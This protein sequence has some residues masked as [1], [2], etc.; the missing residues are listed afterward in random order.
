MAANKKRCEL[1]DYAM[2]L[3]HHKSRELVGAAGFTE[4]DVEDLEQTLALDLVERLPR[5]DAA[6]A[7]ENTFVARLVD[8]KISKLIR[9]RD[10]ARRDPE[11]EVCSLSDEVTGE[12]GLKVELGATIGQDEH[13]LRCGK[14]NRP[15]AERTDLQLDVGEAVAGLPDDLR[16]IAEALMVLPVS[17]AAR[18]LGIPR[19]KLYEV[20]LPK[21]REAFQARGL[22]KCREIPT[23]CPRTGYV[24]DRGPVRNEPPSGGQTVNVHIDLSVLISESDDQYHAQA[25]QHLSSHQLIDF[26]KSPLLHYRK[27]TGLVED[28]DSPAFLLGRAAHVRILE[29]RDA[30]QA[31]FALGGPINEKTGRPFGANTK[32][33][34]EWAETQGKPVLSQDH[35]ELIEKMAAG[36]AMNQEAVDLLLCGRV[37][38]VVRATYAT[39]SCQIRIDW[40]HP[41]RGIVDLK[42]CDELDWFE[43][44]ARRYHYANQVAFYQ[45]VLANAIG[46]AVP[47]YIVAVEKREPFRC[48]VWR[49]SD[50]ALAVARQENEAAIQRL[51]ACREVGRWPTGYEVVRVLDVA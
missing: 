50:D 3:I 26:M 25:A 39:V 28:K 31:R 16:P 46:K 45:S 6:K 33:F 34:A 41:H 13:D 10:R 32:A 14:Y 8:R 12:D 24:T 5:F 37:E 36:V 15:S 29:G 23:D 40:T 22:G 1:T 7:T 48:G 35:V 18:K 19:W 20:Y 17:D 43:A 42:T 27:F 44:D 30:Y 9:D 4:E 21:L 47:V 2:E 49:V 38:G 51:K 11:R